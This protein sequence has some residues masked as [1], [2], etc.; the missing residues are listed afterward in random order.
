[1]ENNTT[2]DETVQ[3][4]ETTPIKP[5]TLQKTTTTVEPKQPAI[6]EAPTPAPQPES[7]VVPEELAVIWTDHVAMLD[8]RNRYIN[9]NIPFAHKKAG[10]SAKEAFRLQN[11]FAIAIKNKFPQ[12]TGLNSAYNPDNRTLTV[13][14]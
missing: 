5:V 6:P 1:M 9:S 8:L 7:Y 12:L 13:V 11:K 4:T 3:G 10:K 14:E 2:S